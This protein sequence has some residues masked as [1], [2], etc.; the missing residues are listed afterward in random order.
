MPMTLLTLYITF[1]YNVWNDVVPQ[2]QRDALHVTMLRVSHAAKFIM[3]EPE[4]VEQ[5]DVINHIHGTSFVSG[6]VHDDAYWS[7]LHYSDTCHVGTHVV[8]IKCAM[9]Y[10][11]TIEILVGVKSLLTYYV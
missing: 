2:S 5:W 1:I 6:F 11:V 7:R 10:Y 9:T 8:H 3:V 4:R